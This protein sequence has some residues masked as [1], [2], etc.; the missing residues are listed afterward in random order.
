MVLR[1]LM[2]EENAFVWRDGR[3]SRCFWE[4]LCVE[5]SVVAVEGGKKRTRVAT[6]MGKVQYEDDTPGGGRGAHQCH[7]EASIA[8]LSTFDAS[9]WY[10]NLLPH[11][12]T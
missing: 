5:K 12:S 7:I 2:Q 4:A 10:A 1:Y 11:M 3:W 8:V 6:H 9:I